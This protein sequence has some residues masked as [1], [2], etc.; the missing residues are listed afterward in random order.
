M[1]PSAHLGPSVIAR[2]IAALVA[3]LLALGAAPVAAEAGKKAK[4]TTSTETTSTET[5]PTQT[6]GGL[7]RKNH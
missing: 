3:G 6:I 7:G 2:L 1:T 4:T 5:I